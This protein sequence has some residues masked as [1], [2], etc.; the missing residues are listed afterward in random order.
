L[1]FKLPTVLRFWTLEPPATATVG[2]GCNSRGGFV[3]YH[4]ATMKEFFHTWRRK[5]GVLTLVMA[6]AAMGM[7]LRS[8][9]VTD[10]YF[11]G[12]GSPPHQQM[13]SLVSRGPG[14]MWSRDL[15]PEG[16]DSRYPT[17]LY[18]VRHRENEPS[19]FAE[20][21]DPWFEDKFDNDRIEWRRCMLGFQFGRY[22]VYEGGQPEE[23]V[24]Y[25]IIPYW[26]VVLP[27]TL[28]SACLILW[29]PRK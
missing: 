28:L 12:G 20:Y 22:Q 9:V 1:K 23:I 15:I 13:Q 25:W 5:M 26:S 16:V 2:S 19:G 14:I 3:W 7:W 21:I 27:L 18:T 24:S 6:C 29:K 8:Q 11:F 10:T 4:L 17:G